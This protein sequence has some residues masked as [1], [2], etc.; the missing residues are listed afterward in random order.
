MVGPVKL[1]T[2]A[3][4]LKKNLIN[5]FVLGNKTQQ[6]QCGQDYIFNKKYKFTLVITS[7]FWSVTGDGTVKLNE[8]LGVDNYKQ[9][10]YRDVNDYF[11]NIISLLE[12]GGHV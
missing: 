1:W 11:R 5:C 7:F 3:L 8:Y 10:I 2:L 9:T 4:T 6:K 12:N